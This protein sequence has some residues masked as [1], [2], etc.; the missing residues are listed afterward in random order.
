ML[1]ILDAV[2]LGD[3][4]VLEAL[5]DAPEVAALYSGV[6]MRAV[7]RDA[8]DLRD[9][10]DMGYEVV[11]AKPELIEDITSVSDSYKLIARYPDYGSQFVS[12]RGMPELNREWWRGK[13]LGLLDDPHSISA[14]QVPRAALRQWDL[15]AVPEIVYFP[16]HS[17]L[18]S[19][20]VKG[21]VDVIAIAT[22]DYQAYG[23]FP[24]PQG[25]VLADRIPGPGWYLHTD[26]LLTSIH[27]ALLDAL[28]VESR[29]SRRDY[30]NRI[31]IE[32]PCDG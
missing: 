4:R 14:Y 1:R 18:Y 13:I 12:L 21:E 32:R 9:L 23:T 2:Y 30:L 7:H 22:T 27:C 31:H 6:E 29:S 19:A 5:C 8:L 24:L 20:L 16:T 26:L 11:L 15:E 25:L 3:T 10:Y 17:Q 28:T